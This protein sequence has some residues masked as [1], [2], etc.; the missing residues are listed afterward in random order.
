MV[1]YQAR[2]VMESRQVSWDP[3]WRDWLLTGPGGARLALLLV[4]KICLSMSY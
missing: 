2:F 4:G 1:P 3:F